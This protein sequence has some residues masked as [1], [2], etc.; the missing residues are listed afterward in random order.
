MSY[1]NGMNCK[2]CGGR[3][4]IDRM[5]TGKKK[6]NESQQDSEQ[7]HIELACVMCG[8]RWTVKKENALAQWLIQLEKQ[9]NGAF[10]TS[11]SR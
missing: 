4:F 8:K 1:V 6:K 11:T 3:V 10:A 2:K 5:F 7:N 9:R